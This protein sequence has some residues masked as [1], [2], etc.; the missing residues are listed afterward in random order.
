LKDDH[1]ING[2]SGYSESE[3]FHKSEQSQETE[4]RR[5]AVALPVQQPQDDE[6]PEEGHVEGPHAVTTSM[7]V[8]RRARE[9]TYWVRTQETAELD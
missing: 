4:V 3:G 1:I 9:S 8:E 2:S 5:M 7:G 6:G